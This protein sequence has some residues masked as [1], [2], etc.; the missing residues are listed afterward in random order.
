MPAKLSPLT[1]MLRHYLEVKAEHPDAILMYRMGDFFELFFDDARRAAPILEVQLTARQK[2]TDSEAPMCG[3]PHHALEGYVGKLLAAGLKV[4]ICDQVE[5]PAEAKGLVRREVVRVMTPGTVSEPALLE[6]KEENLLAAVVW[7]PR[8]GE[9]GGGGAAFLDVSTGHFF[10]R[11]WPDGEAGVEDL[12]LL[13]PREVLYDEA[14]L[15]GEIA[16]WI[17]A[18]VACR[19]ALGGDRLLDRAKAAELL[20]RQFGTASLR[21][22]GLDRGEPAV[23]AAAAALAY[24]R[25]TQQSDLSH[26]RGLALQETSDRA[27]LDPTT[28]ANLEVF[29]TLREGGRRGSLLSVLDRT[30]TAPGGRTLRDWLRRPLRLPPA[31][32]GR[33]RAVRALLEDPPR[34]E[35]IR[36]LLAAIGDPERLL[37]RA[38]LGSLT[39]REA[40]GLR[41]SLATLPE[42]FATLAEVAGRAAGEGGPGLPLAAADAVGSVGPGEPSPPGEGGVTAHG[43]LLAGLAL[44]DP[45]AGLAADLARTL[46]PSPAPALAQGGVIAAGVDDELDRCRSLARDSKRHILALEARERQATGIGS[47]KIRYNKVFGYYVEVTKSHQHRVPEHYIRKQTLVNAERYVTPEIKELEEQI[48][49]AEGRQI[50]LEEEH[51]ARLRERVVAAGAGIAAAAAAVGTLD[52]LAAFAEVAA[53]HRYCE[54]RMAAAGAPIVIREGRHPVV[55]RTSREAFVPNDVELDAERAEIVILTGPNMGGKST[56]LRQVALIVLMAQAGSFV[57]AAS[58]SIGVVDRIFTRVG[59]SDDLSRGESTFMVEMIETANILRHATAESLV[60]LDE[61]GRGTATFDGLSLAW[62]IVEYLHENRR[63]KTLFATHYHELTELATLLPRVVNRT[64]AV[65]EWEDRIVFLRRVVAGS[66]DKSYGLHVARLAGLPAEVVARAEEVLAN[67]EAQEY[68]FTGPAAAG[69]RPGGAGGGACARR[70]DRAPDEPLRAR[71]RGG[72]RGAPRDRSR[73]AVAARSAHPPPRPEGEAT[74]SDAGGLLVV[75][76]SGL[77]LTVAERELLAALAPFGVILFARNVETPGQLAALVAEIR[78]AAPGTLLFI[79]AEGGRVDRLRRV[80]GAAPPAAALAASPPALALRAGRWI[81]HALRAFDLD[82]TF[83]PVVDLDRGLTGNAL[84]GRTLG[85]RPRAVAARA[86]AFL[87]GLHG[88]GAGGC[89]KH[90]PGLGGAAEDTHFEGSRV[91]LSRDELE[92]DLAPFRALAATAGAVMLAHA[93]YPAFDPSSR[94]AS[95]SAAIAGRLLRDDLGFTGVAFSD[96]LEMH[97]LDRWGGLPERAEATLAAGCDALLVCSRLAEAP[98]VAACLASRRLGSRRRQALARLAGYREHLKGLRRGSRRL[99]LATVR[100]RLEE[101]SGTS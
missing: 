7:D 49:T 98:E 50:A 17:E 47:L 23:R 2:G 97:A 80:V 13:R 35:R 71:R 14:G 40:A 48:L 84:D 20:E 82:V 79:D 65:K 30:V 63:P 29:R 53:R 54:P 78:R 10:V 25:D 85:S 61:V 22:F 12:E 36:E 16:A 91:A 41:D 42:L 24:A 6:G 21:G 101:I 39:P 27:V 57:P 83:A 38:V 44:T 89:V 32:A 5:D 11:R 90:F 77:S 45:L 93:A 18:R 70:G 58:A 59:A 33:H 19:T 81:G 67:L 55:E 3:V 60:I 95:L 86:R 51:F 99:S 31:I 4:A 68:D 26:V 87:G 73:P 88:A 69:P 92:R 72:G 9:N 75:G 56:Y 94:P 8:S 1:P 76:V 66:A 34:R 52:A 64:L 100:R 74:M 62:A 43:E 96:D 15:P 28:L 37:A 46:E